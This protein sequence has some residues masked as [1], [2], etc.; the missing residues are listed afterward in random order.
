VQTPTGNK[1]QEVAQQE[2]RRAEVV[3]ATVA[4]IGQTP[5]SI[6]KGVLV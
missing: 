6:E 1:R 5:S 3:S 2:K 4:G